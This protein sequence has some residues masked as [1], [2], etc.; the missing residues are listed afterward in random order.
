MLGNLFH[1]HNGH[2][3][4]HII[5]R[6]AGMPR[7]PSFMGIWFEDDRWGQDY[8]PETPR[9]IPHTVLSAMVEL[10]RKELAKKS[11]IS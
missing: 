5:P 8:T 4:M 2:G 3:H 6:Y 11:L 10:L 7:P 1:E 9:T